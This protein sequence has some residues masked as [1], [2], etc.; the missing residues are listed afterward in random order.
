[1]P[2]MPG[3]GGAG[4]ARPTAPQSVP[5]AIP[6]PVSSGANPIPTYTSSRD[7]YTPSGDL[8]TGLV[9]VGGYM[10][11]PRLGKFDGKL[12]F[13]ILANQAAFL[14]F[15][16]YKTFFLFVKELL[17]DDFDFNFSFLS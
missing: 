2:P 7:I 5:N 17:Q 16:N 13:R 1:M 10:P 11:Q 8:A 9:G 4:A 3:V 12:Y 15:D 14:K 6:S